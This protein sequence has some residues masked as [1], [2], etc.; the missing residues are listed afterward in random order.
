MRAMSN[1]GLRAVA[2]SAPPGPEGLK[3]LARGASIAMRLWENEQPGIN[4]PSVK[5][6]YETVGYVISGRAE[7]ILEGK[8]TILGPGSSWVVPKDAEH[9]YRIL[10]VFTAVEATTPP[11]PL[12]SR[13][14]EAGE[15][16]GVREVR[17]AGP[18]SQQYPP[19]SWDVVDEEADESFPASD[20]PGNY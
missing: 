9:R 18:E 8:T 1:A 3:Y 20:P 14:H 11:V 5:R 4:K 7:L 6:P 13:T 19:K 17:P 12:D 2:T 10:D 16:E 15:S